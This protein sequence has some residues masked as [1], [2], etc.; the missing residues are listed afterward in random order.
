MSTLTILVMGKGGVG[1][2]STVNS[3]I[4]ERAVAVSAFQ[5]FIVVSLCSRFIILLYF[6]LFSVVNHVCKYRMH[7]SCACC[8]GYLCM[9]TL[10]FLCSQKDQGLLWFHGPEQDSH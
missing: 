7:S 10:L 1:K 9:D 5:V 6:F 3:I 4:G 2:S 8:A